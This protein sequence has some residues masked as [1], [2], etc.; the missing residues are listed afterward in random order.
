VASQEPDA[1]CAAAGEIG[2]LVSR[3][4]SGDEHA[5]RSIID[6][7]GRRVFAMARSRVRNDD[8]AEEIT[9]SVFAT[10]AMKLCRD[11]YDERGRFEPWL[12]RITMNR[13]RDEFRRARTRADAT[14]PGVLGDIH[15]GP[16][17]RDD[18]SAHGA[19]ALRTAL[20]QLNEPD[21][22]IIELRHHGQM[23]FKQISAVLGQP[24]GTLLARHH[25]ALK[26]LRSM[27]EA[28]QDDGTGD[29]SP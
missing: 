12:F 11:G 14:D 24:V 25:R 20:G 13:V 18:E 17:R 5:W 22:E 6:L 19:D 21:R 27:L 2:A 4:A 7:Y 3:A 26:K 29:G 28:E 15:A 8:L 1:E 23:S 16:D 10:I 9:Q